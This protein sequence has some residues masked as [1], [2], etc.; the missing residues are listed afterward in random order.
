MKTALVEIKS[1]DVNL[2]N[3]EYSYPESLQE[4]LQVDGEE[5]V[6]KLFTQIR[7]IRF[8]DEI[9][10]QKTGGGLPK[11]VV[12]ALK[13]ADPET[14]RKIAATLGLEIPGITTAVA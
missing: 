11:E 14:L 8:I 2:G 3:F 1:K 10:R 9:R 13:S 12:K 6:F 5:K 4:A 7:K